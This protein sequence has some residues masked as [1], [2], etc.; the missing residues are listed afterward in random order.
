VYFAGS[1]PARSTIATVDDG[2][3]ELKGRLGRVTVPIPLGGPGEI[4]VS[5][6]GGTERFAAWCDEPVPKHAPVVIV[7]ERSPRTV[8]VTPFPEAD[9]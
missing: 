1:R 2:E 4:V 3:E 5:I 7:A 9:I 6:R 8:D